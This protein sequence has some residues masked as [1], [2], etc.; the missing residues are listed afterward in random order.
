MII[1]GARGFAKQLFEIFCQNDELE[2][3][4]F[5]DDI[6]EHIPDELYGIKIL[7]SKEEASD[8][9][10]T[11]ENKFCFGIGGSLNRIKVKNQ[12]EDLGG[13]LSSVISKKAFISKHT[14]SIGI[15]STIL[16][17]SIVEND[18]VLGIGVLLNSFAAIFHDCKIGD[19]SEIAPGAKILGEVAIG[20]NC[21]IGANAVILPKVKI[22][23][24]SVI[25]A[26]AVVIHDVPANSTMVGVPAN[27]I[28]K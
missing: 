6:S 16:T 20:N 26:G 9:F 12:F 1:V 27:R 4:F 21:F 3:L 8:I 14:K 13:E 5:Y 15:G 25:G 22:G 23:E 11:I 24:G 2:N 17:S 10:H 18:A 19:F 7:K 28:E